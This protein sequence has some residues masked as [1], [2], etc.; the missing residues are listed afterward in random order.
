MER[1]QTD[2]IKT[3]QTTRFS[4][5]PINATQERSSG[6]SHVWSR[7]GL[8]TCSSFANTDH[9]VVGQWERYRFEGKAFV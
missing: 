5:N 8:R 1:G 9:Q 6:M 7:Q 2:A 3:K 4:A